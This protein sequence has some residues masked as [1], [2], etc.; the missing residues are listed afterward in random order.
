VD[1]TVGALNSREIFAPMDGLQA[2]YNAKITVL[3]EIDLTQKHSLGAKTSI[4]SENEQ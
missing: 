4:T 3:R 2:G 1:V